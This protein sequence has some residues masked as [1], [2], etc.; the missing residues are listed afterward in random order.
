[1]LTLPP[2]NRRHKVGLYL[3]LAGA[4]L[5]LLFEASA[6]QTAGI[7]LLGL[8]AT[9]FFGGLPLRVLGFILGSATCCLGLYLMIA[10]V[11]KE[12]ELYQTRIAAY[13]QALSDI[14]EAITKAPVWEISSPPPEIDFSKPPAQP[15]RAAEPS[16]QPRQGQYTSADIDHVSERV[17]TIPASAI[18][19]L[20]P[21]KLGSE[22]DAYTVSFPSRMPVEE[23]LRAFQNSTATPTF[24]FRAAIRSHLLSSIAGTVLFLL[25]LLGL[26][27]L[28]W[29][30]FKGKKAAE[31]VNH[32]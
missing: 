25:G 29:Q 26:I 19:F 8:A 11:W 24:S 15:T 2:L 20:R 17:V 1:M 4:G 13:D 12:R 30:P 14:R 10:P 21:D 28:I 31:P 9:W 32:L 22:W 7:V 18:P 5:G 27:I 23:V 3:V 6:K 16:A